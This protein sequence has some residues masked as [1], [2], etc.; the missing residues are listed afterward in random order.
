[1]SLLEGC[2]NQNPTNGNVHIEQI[3]VDYEE[4]PVFFFICMILIV[5]FMKALIDIGKRF[6]FELSKF[7]KN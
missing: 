7:K 4:V 1:M 5:V 6:E 3:K 2:K